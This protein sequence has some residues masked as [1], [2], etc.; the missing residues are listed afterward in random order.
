VI[1]NIDARKVLS[2]TFTSGKLK[3]M[4]QPMDAVVDNLIKHLEN[5]V[6][7]DPV[8]SVKS[9]YQGSIL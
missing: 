2:P 7:T 5:E 4:M 6:K 9:V 8:I 1:H 3:S